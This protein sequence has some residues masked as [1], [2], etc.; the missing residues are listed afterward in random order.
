[1]G[2]RLLESKSDRCKNSQEPLVEYVG[3]AVTL[4]VDTMPCSNWNCTF[5]YCFPSWTN[6]H[7]KSL[8]TAINESTERYS[9]FS[10]FFFSPLKSCIFE[11]STS[12]DVI[13]WCSWPET[14]ILQSWFFFLSGVLISW[15][16][17]KIP[18]YNHSKYQSTAFLRQPKQFSKPWTTMTF[19]LKVRIVQKDGAGLQ[20]WGT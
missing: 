5:Q 9:I 17:E 19:S 7:L 12:S 18:S 16:S 15:S 3:M 13:S 1:M 6:W 10:S 11:S 14:F 8:C 20:L 2:N 4:M